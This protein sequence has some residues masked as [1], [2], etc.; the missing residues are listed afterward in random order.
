MEEEEGVGGGGLSDCCPEGGAWQSE[1]DLST[2]LGKPE[3]ERESSERVSSRGISVL[4]V[5]QH[6][7]SVPCEPSAGST[8][9][10]RRAGPASSSLPIHTDTEG[11]RY[12]AFHPTQHRIPPCKCCSCSQLRGVLYARLLSA[13]GKHTVPVQCAAY[14]CALNQCHDAHF[15]G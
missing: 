13:C 1:A 7:R 8:Q 10:E 11:R 6:C 2:D 14:G 3:R 9:K 12:L 5:F 15:D 4:T